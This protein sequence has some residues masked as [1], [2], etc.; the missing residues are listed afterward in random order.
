MMS[1][2]TNGRISFFFTDEYYSIYFYQYIHYH[3]F[4]IHS[5]IGGHRLFTCLGYCKWCCNEHGDVDTS[6]RYWFHFLQLCT[7]KWGTSILFSIVAIPIYTSTNN[8]Q[9]FP[10]LHIFARTCY[11][12]VFLI[13]AILPG[14]ERYLAVVFIC[15]S[16]MINDVEHLFMELLAICISSLEKMSVQFL[17]P[18]FK[19]Q[20][21]FFAIE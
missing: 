10:L 7:Q 2:V 16:P 9:Q 3:I 14:V 4:F 18:V 21:Y 20:V 8:P 15:I 11:L 5:F 1:D 6:L 17:C 13:I 12:L 19:N